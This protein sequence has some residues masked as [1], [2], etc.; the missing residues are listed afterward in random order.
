MDGNSIKE[1]ILWVEN[2]LR[3]ASENSLRSK[4]PILIAVSKL[5]PAEKIQQAYDLGL[6]VFAENY[7]QELREKKSCL[8]PDISWHFI[9]R[10]QKKN[11]K[12]IV[13]EVDLIHS[14]STVEE[15]EAVNAQASK[16]DVV[17]RVL[18]Q[19]N[20]SG[21]LSKAG[22][23]PEEVKSLF[24]RFKTFRNVRLSG[25]MTMPPFSDNPENSRPFFRRLREIG[26]EIVSCGFFESAFELSMGTSQDFQVAIEEGATM[27][28]VGAQILGERKS[29]L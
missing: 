22:C 10:I 16:K 8:P 5:Q 13:G 23:S 4:T 2:Q 14:I 12:Y 26:D 28:R 29:S 18:I 17:Q 15:L 9:G 19:V 7:P 21:E 20:L 3:F 27:V 6:R 1:R 25:L 11:L 24:L